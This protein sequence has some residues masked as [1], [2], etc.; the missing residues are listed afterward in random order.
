MK[1]L[2]L[3]ITFFF[4]LTLSSVCWALQLTLPDRAFQGD[5][6]VGKVEPVA[7]VF[8]KGKEQPVSGE[9][10]F[11]I[12]VPRLQKTDLLITATAGKRRVSK[13]VRVLAYKWKIQRI[14][15]LPERHVNPPP[16]ALERI[17]KDNQ[18]VRKI[19][20]S[21]VHPVALFLSDGFIAPVAGTIT[22]VYGSQRI[23]NGQPRSPHSGVD[24]AAARGTP[25]VSPANG[26]IRLAAKDMYLMGNTLMIDH[27]LGL[28]SIFIHLDSISASEGGRVEQGEIVARVGQTGRATG[29]HLHWGISVG[30]T[31]IDA[32]RLLN[33]ENLLPQQ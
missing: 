16:E 4:F 11:V 12:G 25:V 13:T 5:L 30:S 28:V 9:G 3:S 23:L 24:F 32:A 14:D 1:F 22:G 21:R 18:K 29:P 17:K 33:K 27:G 26:I 10:Y 15:G 7:A 2:F 8:L 20:Q 19:R 6:I 31:S